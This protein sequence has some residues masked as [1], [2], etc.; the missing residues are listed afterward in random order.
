MGRGFGDIQPPCT[1]LYQNI[2]QMVHAMSMVP[3]E[4]M[5]VYIQRDVEATVA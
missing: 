2:I 5:R 4:E 3:F 1:S